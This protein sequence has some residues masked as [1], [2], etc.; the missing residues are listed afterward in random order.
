MVWHSGNTLYS[1]ASI[2]CN[3]SSDVIYAKQFIDTDSTAYFVDP[4]STTI[5]ATLAGPIKLGTITTSGIANFTFTD[6]STTSV[7]NS[8]VVHNYGAT[9]G[10]AAGIRFGTYADSGIGATYAKQFIGAVRSASGSGHGDIVFCNRNATDIS[11]VVL[12]DEKLRITS[13]GAVTASVEMR[14]PIFYDSAN[15]AF[16]FDGNSTGTSIN[17]AGSIIA[18]GNVTA[19][20]DI[21]LK[22]DVQP[23]E[24]ALDKVKQI[25]GVTY[26][27]KENNKRQTGV[28]AQ[29]VL[30]VLPEAIEGSEE[31]MYS[32]AYGNMVGLLVEAIKEQQKQIEELRAEVK[33]LRG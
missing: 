2:F 29:D 5:S 20:S 25:N 24:N 32:V 28:I 3:P 16:L 6:T 31:G 13:A 26:T 11:S 7:L 18:A 19:Y 4:G 9:T 23:I 17:V 12:A 21:R 10:C 33:A 8:M 27:R 1:T 22:T 15:T 30:K 14:S